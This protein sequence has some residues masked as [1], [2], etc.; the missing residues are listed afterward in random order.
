MAKYL[1]LHASSEVTGGKNEFSN[2]V[3]RLG[4]VFD[5][6]PSFSVDQNELGMTFITRNS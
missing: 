3:C 4:L 2:R 1:S 6:F 5:G